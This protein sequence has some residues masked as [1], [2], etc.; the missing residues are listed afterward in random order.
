MVSR[1]TFVEEYDVGI[2]DATA[3]RAIRRSKTRVVHVLKFGVA[4]QQRDGIQ[5][6]PVG[7]E[8]DQVALKLDASA[9]SGQLRYLR[10]SVERSSDPCRRSCR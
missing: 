5:K 7:I 4:T 2:H 3:R 1:N 9:R 6:D 10:D 8:A